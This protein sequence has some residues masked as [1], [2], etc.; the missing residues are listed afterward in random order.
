MKKVIFLLIL[1]LPLLTFAQRVRDLTTQTT[2]DGSAYTIIDKVGYTTSK[3]ISL[4]VLTGTEATARK[5]NDTITRRGVGLT[6]AGNY[7]PDD[8]SNY[9]TTALMAGYDTNSVT[10]A[11]HIIDSAL[12]KV[13]TGLALW[14]TGTVAT[15]ILAK[16]SGSNQAVGAYSLALNNNNVALTANSTAK[17][18]GSITQRLYST[19]TASGKAVKI[20]DANSMEYVMKAMTR[21]LAVDTLEIFQYIYPVMA[22]DQLSKFKID[23]IGVC[24]SGKVGE[25]GAYAVTQSWDFSVVNNAGTTSLISTA[26]TTTGKRVGVR[27]P[28]VV[29]SVDDTTEKVYLKVTGVDTMRFRWVAYV[30]ETVA[31][32]RNFD[33]GY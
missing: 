25:P 21:N 2:Y 30:R 1:S 32:F 3:K 6:D 8:A 13:S 19:S 29:L 33:L 24:D 4:S 28:K 5:Q 16:P 15:A 14:D 20:G 12:Y 31:G 27:M 9:I 11:L 26:D 7:Q 22:A 23:I 18:Y 10:T 17:G